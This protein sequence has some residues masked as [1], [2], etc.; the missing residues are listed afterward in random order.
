MTAERAGP[1]QVSGHFIQPTACLAVDRLPLGPEWEYELKFDGY[2]AIGFKTSDRGHLMSRNGKDFSRRFP[3]LAGALEVL[4]DDTVIDGE[5]V[6]MDE[7][8]QPSFNLLQNHAGSEYSPVFY[9]FDLLILAGEDLRNKPLEVRRKLLRAKVMPQFA[10][11]IRFSETLHASAAEV[12]R[13]V[14]DQGL[15][16]VIA[17]RRGS[18]YQPGRRSGAW[19][20]MQINQGQ[21]LIIGGYVPT[22]NNFDSIVFGYYEGKKLMYAARVRSGFVPASR[23]SVFKRFRGL[24]LLEKLQ[25]CLQEHRRQRY[26]RARSLQP[27]ATRCATGSP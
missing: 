26:R 6:A 2:R 17:K 1:K 21:E 7:T 9:V 8:G 5:V 10:E 11:P 3:M 25:A 18:P 22:P 20:K 13:A 14:R 12:V 16:G 4:P 27:S 15:E 23:E 19:V 24:E